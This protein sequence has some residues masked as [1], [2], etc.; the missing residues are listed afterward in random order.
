MTQRNPDHPIDPIFLERWSPRAFD[1]EAMPETDLLALIEA[2]RWAPSAYNYQPWRFLYAHRDDAHWQGFLDLLDPFNASWARHASAII[3]VL[4]D[5]LM[6]GG[7]AS[8][9][10][11]SHSHSFDTGAAWAQLALQATRLGYHAHAMA[12]IDFDRARTRLNVPDRFR[13]EI[14]VAVGR[15]ADP[16]T[17]PDELQRR[18]RPS[19]R[20]PVH[21][22]AFPGS[23]PK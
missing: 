20:R 5:M 17:L 12:G 9:P 23:F 3:F 22:F 2:A 1:A 10:S 18:E 4:S 13:I 14:A 19:Q 16:A 6:P 8:A 21:E 15:R 11:P 7:V